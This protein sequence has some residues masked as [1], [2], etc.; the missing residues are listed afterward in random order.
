MKIAV[1]DSAV[2]DVNYNI[3]GAG[4]P[5]LNLELGQVTRG[6]VGSDSSGFFSHVEG[7]AGVLRTPTF[8]E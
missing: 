2:L 8:N 7:I 5:A 4:G 6:I 1:A 3:L